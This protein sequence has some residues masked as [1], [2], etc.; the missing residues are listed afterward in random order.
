[1]NE[2]AIYFSFAQFASKCLMSTM[3]ANYVK[4]NWYKWC[5]LCLE[6]VKRTTHLTQWYTLILIKPTEQF[7]F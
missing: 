3:M 7:V 4:E 1:M 5:K 6:F 2:F